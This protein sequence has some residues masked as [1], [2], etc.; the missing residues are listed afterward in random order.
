MNQLLLDY[1][2]IAVFIGVALAIASSWQDAPADAGLAVVGEVG[3]LGEL[4][5]V[6]GLERRLREAGRLGFRTAI[7]PRPGRGSR[8][9]DVPGMEVV[10]VATLR[11]A[12]AVGLGDGPRSRGD[13]L[14]A[15]LG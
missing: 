9:I 7:V 2:P 6:A 12:I 11:D 8:A 5:S 15:M 4:R 14:P 3:L 13:A 1:L 10:E